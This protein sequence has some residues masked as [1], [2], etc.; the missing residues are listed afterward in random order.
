MLPLALL[1]LLLVTPVTDID[2]AFVANASQSGAYET[3]AGQFAMVNANTMK[4]K[5][6]AAAEAR[7]HQFLAADLKRISTANDIPVVPQLNPEFAMRLAKL[8]SALGPGFDLA[9]VEDMKQIH[10]KDQKLFAEEA[11]DGSVAF[12]RFAAQAELTV[13]RHLA[14]V[15]DPDWTVFRPATP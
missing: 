12:R 6:L 14:A 15:N 13:R 11:R 4:V 10:E 1:T 5:D 3:E 2:R 7:D 9:Y 8:K